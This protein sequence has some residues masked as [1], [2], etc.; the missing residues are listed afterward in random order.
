MKKYYFKK[1]NM[2]YL[3][4]IFCLLFWSCEESI[5]NENE[6]VQLSWASSGSNCYFTDT[7][8]MCVGLDNLGS[9]A[10][11]FESIHLIDILQDWDGNTVWYQIELCDYIPPPM[12][13]GYSSELEC[14]EDGYYWRN[15]DCYKWY[16]Y[17]PPSFGAGCELENVYII[18]YE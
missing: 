1:F 13:D 14:E 15:S 4:I 16:Y 17:D 7:S 9:T 2:R 18:E 11:R 12:L 8:N 3:L 5:I 6:L 10:N